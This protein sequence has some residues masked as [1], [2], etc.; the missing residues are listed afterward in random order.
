MRAAVS[1]RE[2][3]EV[4]VGPTVAPTDGSFPRSFPPGYPVHLFNYTVNSENLAL[5]PGVDTSLTD[6]W[7]GKNV[8]GLG[9]RHLKAKI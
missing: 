8:G 6:A 9:G 3:I 1:F 4:T 7:S 5:E 2:A